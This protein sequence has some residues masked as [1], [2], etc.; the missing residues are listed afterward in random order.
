[1]AQIVNTNLRA[2]SAQNNLNRT[3]NDLNT[4][5][6]RLSSGLR[7]NSAK[8]DA[9]GL[10]IAN[11]FTSQINGL[12][13]AVRNAND[14][15]SFAQ[16]AEGAMSEI[17]TALQRIRDLALQ[18]T[19]GSNG[20]EQRAALQQE[21]GQMVA[22]IDRIASQTTFNGLQVLDGSVSNLSF[23]IGANVGETVS[24]DGVDVRATALGSAPGQVQSIGRRTIL[25]A[26]EAGTQGL[27]ESAAAPVDIDNFQVYTDE[28]AAADAIDV[29]DTQYGGNIVGVTTANLIDRTSDDYGGGQAKAVAERINTIRES[30]VA[31]L[32]GV[33]ASAVNTFQGSDV[34]AADYAGGVDANVTVSNVG[35]GSLDNGDLVINGVD[36]GPV[37]FLSDD[38]TGTLV[39][40]INSKSDI[41][42]VT[43]AVNEQGEL[44][45][46]AEDGRD[47][48]INTASVAVT[49]DLF[50]GGDELATD[51]FDADFTN[52]R[53]AGRLQISGQDTINFAGTDADSVG[54]DATGLA[55]AGSEDNVQASGSIAYADVSTVAGANITIA[56]VDSALSQVDF[57]RAQLGAVQNRLES[58][59]RNLSSVQESLTASRSRI[60]DADFAAESTKL[61]RAQVLQQAGI[62]VLAQ[63]NALPQSVLSLL[64]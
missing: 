19:N 31:E 29:A 10:A 24:L 36:I 39:E 25:A 15:I 30:G 58:T 13:Q 4:A 27:Q 9:A 26:G 35:A 32:Q 53:V 51:R 43:A 52:L 38:S 7:V 22:E 48:V 56:S 18:A 1:M 20:A 54:V 63:A 16:T 34:A 11:K 42:G 21:V 59:I 45:L 23:Q 49:N 37:E 5:L 44:I 3:G 6:Q 57:S 33:Y 50:G 2:T 28:V 17:T 64:G 40:A 47:M 41:S 60:L 12:G 14:G 62:S 46:T 8:D 61:A 55:A